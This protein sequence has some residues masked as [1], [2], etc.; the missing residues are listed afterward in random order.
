MSKFFSTVEI[1]VTE[2]YIHR[3]GQ[4]KQRLFRAIKHISNETEKKLIEE[5][6]LFAELAHRDAKRRTG[7]PYIIHPV[8]VAIIVAQMGLDSTSIIC[9]LLH[10][11][12]EDTVY[13]LPDMDE[14][15]GGTVANIINGLT[16][17]EEL[18]DSNSN[19]QAENIRKLL[20]T[21]P[22]DI[23]IVFI[24]IADRL[25]NMRTMEAMPA[26]KQKKKADETLFVY[27]PLAHRL[28]LYPIKRELE[29]LGFKYSAPESYKQIVQ[30]IKQ[31]HEE[32]V[33]QYMKLSTPIKKKLEE[34]GIDF[35]IR[36][37][38]KST[39]STW[40]KM[41]EMNLSFNE[42]HNFSAIRI[43]FNP[44][45]EFSE[46]EQCFRIYALITELYKF[47]ADRF[48]D[49]V[50]HPRLNG[51]EALHGAI[52]DETGSLVEFQ[53]LSKRMNNVAERGFVSQIQ[54]NNKMSDF[55]KW[56]QTLEDQINTSNENTLDFV[57]DIVHNL[58]PSDIQVFTPKGEQIALP[59]GATVLDFAFQ[60]HSGLGSHCTGAKVT[61]RI[62]GRQHEL[63][64]QDRIEVI[65]S[66][67]QKP[68]RDWLNFVVTGRART[69]VKKY[70]K[71][72]T[73]EKIEEGKEILEQIIQEKTIKEPFS[74]AI[75]HLSS[76]LQCK[77]EN[78]LL[79]KIGYKQILREDIISILSP[80]KENKFIEYWK[81][82]KKPWWSKH[83]E[84]N[85]EDENSNEKLEI[86]YIIALCCKPIPGDRVFGYKG[87]DGSLTIHKEH[88]EV[89]RK[90][91]ATRGIAIEEV[92][93]SVE[94]KKSFEVRIRIEGFDRIGII[95]D[96]TNL[97]SNELDV[98]MKAI[99]VGTRSNAFEGFIDLYIHNLKDLNNLKDRIKTIKGIINVD[100]VEIPKD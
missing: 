30:T 42:I 63:H 72:E 18:V 62:V 34:K 86:E 52:I 28:G 11:V 96:L 41:Q 66:Q 100:R 21:I 57:D 33:A 71:K 16:K 87:E 14:L 22:N 20:T 27:A 80:K 88:C 47:S 56:V 44:V 39:Y 90:L 38:T 75:N 78:D 94:S 60:I 95:S 77:N 7:E 15:Y 46:R 32:R 73:E 81:I 76:E 89:A 70:F 93:W 1:E 91:E 53:I 55:N 83:K 61:H 58:F 59:K 3:I 8:E 68:E 50:N 17:I 6:F 43:I 67:D 74:S 97:I 31:S 9:G 79:E 12:V 23:R 49:W 24:K 13:S 84:N 98:N 26:K 51:Y 25:H 2:E 40:L 85:K 64:D 99:N 92:K 29:N 36:R 54:L 65:T 82:I 37:K 5:A 45:P 69:F 19:L 4:L 35:E 48:R 10:D